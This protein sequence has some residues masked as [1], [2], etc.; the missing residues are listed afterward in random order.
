VLF[1]R[2]RTFPY[3]LLARLLVSVSICLLTVAQ[4]TRAFSS[5]ILPNMPAVAN[6]AQG[7]ASHAVEEVGSGPVADGGL[8]IASS[9][10]DAKV[11]KERQ[12]GP[13]LLHEV[14]A[15]SLWSCEHQFHRRIPP[16]SGDDDN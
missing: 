16:R 1:A 5:I 12:P 2:M 4:T 13:L 6:H 14:E 7:F 10:F 11:P 3:R 9:S 8:S 15:G